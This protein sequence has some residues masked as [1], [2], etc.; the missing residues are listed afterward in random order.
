KPALA[1]IKVA[2]LPLVNKL[3]D[4]ATAVYQMM[5]KDL[6]CEY[7]TSGNIG[8]RYRRQD[9]IGTPFCITVDYQ[10]LDD[11]AVTVRERD[12]MQQNRVKINEVVNYIKE[13]II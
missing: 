8:R 13:R 2:V 9:A 4:K 3:N 12:S 5:I 7:D 10:T 11:D 6:I 1:P